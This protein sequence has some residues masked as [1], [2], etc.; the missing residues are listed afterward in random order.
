M[1]KQTTI[2]IVRHGQA[3]FN[4][5]QIIGGTL[6]PNPLT[7][8]GEEQAR[9]L[10]EKFRNIKIDKIYSSDLLR[11]QKTAAIIASMKNLPVKTNSLLR[12]QSWGILQGKT[13]DKAKKEYPEA[14]LKESKIEGEEA[15]DFKY[16]KNMESLRHAVLR[17]KRFLEIIDKDQTGRT[18]LAV[19]HFDI[20]IGYLVYLRLGI[21]QDLMNA[22]LDHAGYYK[23]VRNE[24]TF[25]A[26]KIVGLN[27]K[28]H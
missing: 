19:T 20:M 27:I 1:N 7:A 4:L 26:E 10:G 25:I 24:K 13:F 9:K 11:A 15:L 28:G 17:L 3:D 8:K 2:Y 18:V 6:D 5:R 12:E 14:F 23:L 16:V 21:Y 22:D